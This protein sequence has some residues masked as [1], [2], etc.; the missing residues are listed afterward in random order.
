MFFVDFKK[1]RAAEI[2]SAIKRGA[3]IPAPASGDWNRYE[4]LQVADAM[5]F[6][7]WC[8]GPINSDLARL[9]NLP[10]EHCAATEETQ[11]Q[12]VQAAIAFCGQ[13]SMLIDDGEYDADFE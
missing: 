1:K 5:Y 12:D 11:T 7:I 13:L 8:H 9:D 6:A 3:P 10:T 4:M 2:L